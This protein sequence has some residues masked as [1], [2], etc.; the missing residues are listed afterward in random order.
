MEHTPDTVVI[1]VA[2]ATSIA[3]GSVLLLLLLFQGVEFSTGLKPE[4]FLGRWPRVIRGFR[5][6]PLEPQAQSA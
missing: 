5:Y 2:I 4:P 3:V 1:A 6:T